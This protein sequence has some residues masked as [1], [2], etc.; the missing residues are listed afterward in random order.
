MN[1]SCTPCAIC[2]KSIKISCCQ[3]RSLLS[4]IYY[5][6][7]SVWLGISTKSI[8][9]IWICMVLNKEAT[10][11]RSMS[12]LLI[13]YYYTRL[14]IQGKKYAPKIYFMILKCTQINIK[15]MV[16][17]KFFCFYVKQ[18]LLTHICCYFLTIERIWYWGWPLSTCLCKRCSPP[19]PLPEYIFKS[20]Q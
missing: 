8:N 14:Y 7:I 1:K 15:C 12:I 4:H 20:F 19:S 13:D 11:T 10:K 6:Y 16:W 17:I 9:K 5:R 18:Y 3:W 2:C